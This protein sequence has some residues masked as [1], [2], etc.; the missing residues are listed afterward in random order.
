[1]KK[2]LIAVLTVAL[3]M[4]L[5]ACGNTEETTEVTTEATVETSEVVEETTAAVE[6]DLTVGQIHANAFEQFI[7]DYDKST[8][9]ELANKLVSLE[10][11]QF[12][13]GAMPVDGE[14][15]PGFDNYIPEG[16][17]SGAMFM[18]QIGSIAYVGYVFELAEDADAEAFANTLTDNCN[19]RWNICV[20]ADQ[21]VVGSVGNTV[22]FL[23]CPASYDMP[24]EEGGM[25]L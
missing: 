6:G 4:G 13:G 23:M 7:A 22:F 16:Y 21:T 9:E 18:P 20:Q 14:Y 19:P 2:L 8:A 25:A 3:C 24:A 11:N 1:M 12:M 10:I 17:V 15:F 5:V